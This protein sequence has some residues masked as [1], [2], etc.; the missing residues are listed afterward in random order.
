MKT[1]IVTRKAISTAKAKLK[2]AY[3]DNLRA[4][5][6]MNVFTAILSE[7]PGGSAISSLLK[8]YIP[9]KKEERMVELL[10]FMGQELIKHADQINEASMKTNHFAF[11]LENCMRGVA[12][13]PQ[14]EKI[15]AYRAILM[16]TILGSGLEITEEEHFLSLVDRLSS[17]HIKVIQ[18]LI[19]A[20][21]NPPEGSPSIQNRLDHMD[22]DII[23]SALS[24][25]YTLNFTNTEGNVMASFV[26]VP[27]DRIG[28][29]LNHLGKKFADFIIYYHSGE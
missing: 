24:E 1:K 7:I 28:G 16:N 19:E 18:L 4:E 15:D 13:S 8:D 9:Q 5:H 22:K 11:M 12:M 27:L 14:K 29:R 17:V 20:S 26:N 6:L 21:Q 23:A 25:L 3:I 2:K 10:H